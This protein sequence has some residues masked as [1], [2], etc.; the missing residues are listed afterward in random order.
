[1]NKKDIYRK[2]T[3]E[4]ILRHVV[5]LPLICL[6]PY[7]VAGADSG[8]AADV[9]GAGRTV[10]IVMNGLEFEP[11]FVDVRAGETIRFK[12][13]NRD[14]IPHDFTIGTPAMQLA[15]RSFIRV[16]HDADQLDSGGK[17]QESH[18]HLNSVLVPPGVTKELVWTFKWSQMIEFGCN[19][20]LHYEGGMKGEFRFKKPIAMFDS[21][22]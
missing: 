3:R 13:V 14:K 22:E 12:I 4:K 1:M 2:T 21:T 20:P 17:M 7:I 11:K 18:D 15:R 10:K 19:V 8:N 5:L 9:V 16:L 6:A